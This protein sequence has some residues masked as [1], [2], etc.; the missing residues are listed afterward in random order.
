MSLSQK[1]R[2][3]SR[4]IGR[5]LTVTMSDQPTSEQKPKPPTPI[6]VAPQSSSALQPAPAITTSDPS[7]AYPPPPAN[8]LTSEEQM[9]LFEKDLKANDWGQQPC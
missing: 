4:P 9:A 7:T 2:N 1:Q 6:P 5:Y 3:D 8:A